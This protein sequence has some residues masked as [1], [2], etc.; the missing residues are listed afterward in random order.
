MRES[1]E[2]LGKSSAHEFGASTYD[3]S[4]IQSSLMVLDSTLVW[5]SV[6]SHRTMFRPRYPSRLVT[7][8]PFKTWNE[9]TVRDMEREQ[10]AQ[11]PN[12]FECKPLAGIEPVTRDSTRCG[13]LVR[14]RLRWLPILCPPSLSHSLLS[15]PPPF[16]CP[17]TDPF[18]ERMGEGGNTRRWKLLPP[19]TAL[20]R[21]TH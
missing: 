8:I 11:Q 18:A 21:F 7:P 17:H 16:S 2:R 14:I 9:R 5:P 13:T 3:E 15:L 6:M 10:N 1:R 12:M 19:T 20:L 4:H